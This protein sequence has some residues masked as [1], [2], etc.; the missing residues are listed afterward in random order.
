MLIAAIILL[1]SQDILKI[2]TGCQDGL[3]R[4]FDTCHPSAPCQELKISSSFADSITKI[5]WCQHALNTL[6]ISKRSGTI[7]LWDIRTN[8]ASG[9]CKAV[10]LPGA[11][12]VMDMELNHDKDCI[13]A[14]TGKQVS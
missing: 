10:N 3:L 2:G 4:I 12:V 9:P 8:P 6:V 5:S 1:H 7:E 13:I 14:A 11:Q